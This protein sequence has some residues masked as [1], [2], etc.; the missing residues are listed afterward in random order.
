MLGEKELLFGT[1]VTQREKFMVSC[2]FE[3]DPIFPPEKPDLR[4]NFQ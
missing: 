1:Q 4:F 3:I 2:P